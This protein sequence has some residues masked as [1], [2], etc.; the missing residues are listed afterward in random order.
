M[1][2]FQ[3]FPCL[4]DNYGVLVHDRVSGETA[5]IDAPDGDAVRAALS[6]KGWTLT[7]I[8]VTHHHWD[9]TQGIEALKA[10]TGC[11]VIGPAQEA[12]KIKLLDQTVDDGDRISFGNEP[13]DILS[14]PGHTLGMVNYHFLESKVVF[15][16]DTLFALGCGRVFEGDMAMMWNSLKKLA[17]LPP[18]TVVYCGH[19]YTASNADFALTVDPDNDALKRRVV[20]IKALR[21]E[22]KPT[23]PTTISAEL[24]TNPFLRAAD[25]AI[26]EVLGMALASDAEVFAEIRGRKDRA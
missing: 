3:Q 16:G 7:H 23:I 21:A 14:T 20:E 17:E 8:L 4:S 9:H 25:P 24:E 6:A 11:T 15:T 13:V 18:E 22:G 10:E 1:L 5:S 2:E 19:E 12:E 26:R